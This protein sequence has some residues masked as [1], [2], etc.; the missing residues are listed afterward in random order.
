MYI[1]GH[2]ISTES[3]MWLI[4]SKDVALHVNSRHVV[5]NGEKEQKSLISTE[6]VVLHVRKQGDDPFKL[7]EGILE[8]DLRSDK[9]LV[10]VVEVNAVD[11]PA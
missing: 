11:V 2:R 9:P 10:D 7:G 4:F 5:Q 6:E 1:A 8:F 3:Y